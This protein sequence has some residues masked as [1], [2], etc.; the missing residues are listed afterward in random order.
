MKILVIG[1]CDSI[2]FAKW[3]AQFTETHHSFRIVPSSPHRFI[4]PRLNEILNLPNFSMGWFSRFFSLGLWLADRLFSDYL[5][6]ALVALEIKR[7]RPDIVHVLEFQNAG[8][9][10][11]RAREIGKTSADHKLLLT[12]YGSDIYW[13]QR[14]P[15]HLRKIKKLLSLANGLSSE[16]SRDEQLAAK[17][18][19]RGKFMPRIPAFGSIELIAPDPDRSDRV[20]IA[21]KGYQ[22][23]WGQAVTALKALE[24][25]AQELKEFT[26]EIYSAEGA[27]IVA[28]KRLRRETG[29]KVRIHKKHR[30]SN[31]QVLD[32][33]SKSQIYIGLSRSD[34]ISA[35]M[36]EAMSRGAIP[37]QSDTSCCDE[38]LDDELGGYL[39]SYDDVN[40][41]S[42]HVLSILKNKDFQIRAAQHNYHSLREKLAEAKTKQASMETYNSLSRGGD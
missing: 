17:Y 38:W 2:H 6:G 40:Q 27:A 7:F 9:A 3:L 35:S 13:F 22:N 4:H 32:L 30:L 10:Y 19:F 5:R 18:G 8:Y 1:M 11:L 25:I 37:I 42:S 36:I 12:P 16:C 33:F 23:K 24:S 14:F 26:I 29:L 31:Q 34:G 39:V 41:I 28:A 20:R 21:V 15:K